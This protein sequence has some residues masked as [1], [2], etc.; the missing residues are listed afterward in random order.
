MSKN[1]QPDPKESK[2]FT[3]E[4]GLCIREVHNETLTHK[5]LAFL[6]PPG[7]EPEPEPEEAFGEMFGEETEEEE[8]PDGEEAP[9]HHIESASVAA[10]C[11]YAP[12]G[13][14]L[15]P[16]KVGKITECNRYKRQ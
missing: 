5:G 4:Y 6:D 9:Q 11:F 1:I 14:K 15:M 8:I 13:F 16:I 12:E 3:C 2:C 7:S 10:I